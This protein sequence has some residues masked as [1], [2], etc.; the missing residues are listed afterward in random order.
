MAIALALITAIVVGWVLARLLFEAYEDWKQ[1]AEF[2]FQPEIVSIIFG[3]L[4]E[5][6][7]SEIR[8][9]L[10]FAGTFGSAYFAYWLLT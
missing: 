4:K 10:W 6:L 7:K 8:F 1:C 2:W 9:W 3:E 5:D